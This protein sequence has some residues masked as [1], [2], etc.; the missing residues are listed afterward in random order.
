M[1]LQEAGLEIAKAL[2]RWVQRLDSAALAGVMGVSLMNE[3]AH[4]NALDAKGPFAD[5]HAVLEWLTS[6]AKFFS[7]SKLPAMGK[8][9]YVQISDTA[10]H[11]FLGEVPKWWHSTFSS[12]E[13]SSWAVLDLHWYTAWDRGTCDG[14]TSPG[15][16]YN[17]TQPR[18]QI[19]GVQEHCIRKFAT[20]WFSRHFEGQKVVS[21][22][23][24][25]TYQN[26]PFA[27][28]NKSMLRNF[29]K[30]QV[31]IFDSFEITPFFWTW[32]MPYA[33]V[34]QPGWSLKYLAGLE[35]ARG[36]SQCSP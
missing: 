17:C 30:E 10:F 8:K 2:V 25:A 4:M 7:A 9:L 20:K 16:A 19:E 29:L 14:R 18:S 21:E 33:H 3:P 22:M 13:R 1:T 11:D 15:G 36:K 12:K 31:Q 6:A 27:C 32:R 24:A 35:D 34:F 26:A 23:S 28:T 5:E